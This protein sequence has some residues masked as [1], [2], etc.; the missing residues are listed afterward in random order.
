MITVADGKTKIVT[1]GGGSGQFAL[2]SGLRNL[3][4]IEITAVVSMVDSGGST[5]R[6]RDEYGVLPPGDILKCLIALSPYKD[7]RH[8][9][10]KRFRFH[11]Q[12]KNH[13]AGNLLLVFLSQYLGND[14]VSAVEAFGEML[15]IKGQVL[16]VTINKGTLAAELED[17]SFIFSET[18]IDVVKG[19]RT[20]KIKKT[21]LVPHSGELKAF[22]PAI[23]SIVN[24]DYIIVGPGDLYTSIT[25]NF[26]VEG[27][28]EAVRVS[29]AKF[30]QISNIMTKCGETD[31]F[32]AQ[33]FNRV[34][35]EYLGRKVDLVILNNKRPDPEVLKSYEN[36]KACL[37]ESD[38]SYD[39]DGREIWQEDLL[40]IWM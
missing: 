24:A 11:D 20:S 9:L 14:F 31:N 32:K 21:F 5:G 16:P 19:E 36:E 25:P 7:A 6:L 3:E 37:V 13:N 28:K 10:Q 30:I 18:A 35:E 4:E 33:D 38:P 17:G 26:L 23:E 12:I 34:L 15:E 8:I 2:L 40:S 22:P 27:V 39:W 1:I 29:S